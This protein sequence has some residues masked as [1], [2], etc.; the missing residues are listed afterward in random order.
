MKNHSKS[1]KL[2][3]VPSISVHYQTECQGQ[4]W[5]SSLLVYY[6]HIYETAKLW[7]KGRGELAIR[8]LDF[9]NFESF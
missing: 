7:W 2:Q 8:K 5:Y 1:I 4:T 9:H 6:F 3:T